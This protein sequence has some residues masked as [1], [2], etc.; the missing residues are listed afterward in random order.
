MGR[1]GGEDGTYRADAS[2]ELKDQQH[3]DGYVDALVVGLDVRLCKGEV[4]GHRR[5]DEERQEPKDQENG[6]LRP[7]EKERGRC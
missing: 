2:D 4:D 1:E 6:N 7:K 5:A 3:Q